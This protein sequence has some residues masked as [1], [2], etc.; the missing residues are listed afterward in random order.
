M[1]EVLHLPAQ[2]RVRINLA[3]PQL[4]IQAVLQ[5]LERGSTEEHIRHQVL[6]GQ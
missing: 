4:C 3:S 6:R 2:A 1:Q 5:S